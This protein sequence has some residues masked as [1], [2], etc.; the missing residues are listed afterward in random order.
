[1]STQLETQAELCW[2]Q[3]DRAGGWNHTEKAC[4]L[5]LLILD[6]ESPIPFLLHLRTAQLSALCVLL[7]EGADGRPFLL[8]VAS[9]FCP[10]GR[11]CW[12]WLL[13]IWKPNAA[14]WTVSSVKEVHPLLIGCGEPFFVSSTWVSSQPSLGTQSFRPQESSSAQSLYYFLGAYLI[15]CPDLMQ[16]KNVIFRQHW[17]LRAHGRINMNSGLKPLEKSDL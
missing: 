6:D 2:E 15:V 11:G 1:M 5:Q 14:L 17:T 13:M 3:F 9:T 4:Y 10:R 7:R 12:S 16:V 8:W